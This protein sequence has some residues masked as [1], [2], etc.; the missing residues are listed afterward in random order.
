MDIRKRFLG[1]LTAG[2]LT[3]T[4]LLYCSDQT[5]SKNEGVVSEGPYRGVRYKIIETK[6]QRVI[7]LSSKGDIVPEELEITAT[8]K[9][10][11]S[12]YEKIEIMLIGKETSRIDLST[13]LTN[14]L[15]QAN[16]K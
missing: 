6:N 15:E 5:Y 14:I 1:I 16:S 3:T 2:A 8:D 10:K 11:D 7:R 12:I 13:D 4:G 9:G